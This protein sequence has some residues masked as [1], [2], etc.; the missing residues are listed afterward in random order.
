MQFLLS[1]LVGLL[2]SVSPAWAGD[3]TVEGVVLSISGDTIT[4]ESS[5][6]RTTVVDVSGAGERRVALGEKVT[7]IGE[8]APEL[9]KFRAR[10]IQVASGG[11][12]VRGR[13]N[14]RGG[15]R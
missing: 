3:D 6:G 8:F 14:S 11:S 7:V 10:T 15:S 13:P 12:S 9:N 5:E 2:L 1:L 4:V